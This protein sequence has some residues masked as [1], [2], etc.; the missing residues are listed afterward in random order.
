MSTL[1]Q[2]V[3]NLSPS[4]TLAMAQKSAELK[5]KGF[6][7]INLS[8]GQ[9]D[10]LTPKSIK[11][12][13]KKA[14]D[15]NFTT[16]SPVAGYMDL[17]KAIAEKL[18]KENGLDYAPSQIVCSNGAKQSICNALLSII[19]PG[20][21]VI[22]PSPYWVSYVEMV[23]LADG[24]SKI[25]NTTIEQNFKLSPKQLEEA[26]NEKTKA[27]VLCSPSNPTGAVY[28]KEELEGLANVLL[29][30]PNI[31][32][33]S[34]EIYEHI[35]YIGGH[36]SIAQFKELKDKVVLVNGVSK[37]YSMTGWRLGYIATSQEIASACNKLQ[38]QYTSGPCSI[39]QKAALEA[40][41]GSQ[42][43]VEE[44]RMA[45]ERRR[46][47]IVQLAKGIDG[48]EVNQPEGAFY[49]FPRVKFYF[50][51]SYEGMK[52]ENADDLALFLL[53]KAQV[54]SVGGGSFGDNEC[55]RFSYATSDEDLKRAFGRIKA[56][57]SLLK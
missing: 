54:A 25:V 11:E 44:M 32:I 26:I 4:A 1:S 15:N 37:A 31:I 18:K 43:C 47:L 19:N 46:N 55:I 35:N 3:K 20:E 39:S 16:Y 53:E 28:S 40:Y 56:A 42:S 33:I 38:G 6:D 51:K 27:L 41:M 36:Q 14:I 57:L 34:D 24:V 5:E 9:P 50:G 23:K 12:A 52:I 22:I 8:I 29:R 21:E 2:R 13:G 10:F 30:Y 45:F 17:R 48:F 49:L 7:V